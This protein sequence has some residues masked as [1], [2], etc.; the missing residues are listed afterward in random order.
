[1][2]TAQ[3]IDGFSIAKNLRQ[4]IRQ[5]IIKYELASSKTPGLA[6]I[7]IGSDAASE[8]YVKKK[9]AACEEVK[10][11]S[12]E[13][14]LPAD[15]T[16]NEI[17]EVITQANNNPGINGILVQ[18]PLPSHLNAKMIIEAISPHKD[19]DGFNITNSG[20]LVT[21]GGGLIPCT[22]LGC[23]ILL[24]SIHNDLS[25]LRAI[26]IGRSQIVGRP[27]SH[28]LLRANCTVLSAH[29]HT[30][31]LPEEVKASDI[32][33]SATGCPELVKGEWIKPGAT[34]IDVG[35]TRVTI[36]SSTKQ[37]ARLIGDVCFEDAAKVAGAITPVPGGVGPMTVA[38]LLRNTLSA[39][40]QQNIKST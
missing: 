12:F 39:F 6:V 2:K 19:V 36:G 26:V 22:P 17:L 3:I 7:L 28:V 23:M 15:S 38:S 37:Q 40:E 24:N 1:M 33:I 11:R 4:S 30:R 21:H 8:I 14:K 25:G 10:I 34:I 13:Y 16:E 20:K 9:I 18:M 27:M 31:N 35:I 32:V 29:R 5:Q